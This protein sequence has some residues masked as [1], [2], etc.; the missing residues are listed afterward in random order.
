MAD[1]RWS[2]PLAVTLAVASIASFF[3]AG[4]AITGWLYDRLT[5]ENQ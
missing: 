1:P 2:A 3:A 5:K 4:Y